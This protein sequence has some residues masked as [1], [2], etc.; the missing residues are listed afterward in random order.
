ME[1]I[2]KTGPVGLKGI[3]YDGS[4]AETTASDLLRMQ[5]QLAN[6]G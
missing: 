1:D 3:R 5:A 4:G 6:Q 2:T